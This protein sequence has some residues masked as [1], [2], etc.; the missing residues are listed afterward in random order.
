[1][2]RCYAGKQC[3]LEAG[4]HAVVYR[5]GCVCIVMLL[6]LQRVMGP[7]PW[8]PRHSRAASSSRSAGRRGCW[9]P[10]VARPFR[11]LGMGVDIIVGV[12][13]A[14]CRCCY[15][16]VGFCD[17]ANHR[18]GVQMIEIMTFTYL[19]CYMKWFLRLAWRR[20]VGYRLLVHP[21][22]LVEPPRLL[23]NSNHLFVLS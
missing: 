3:K 7:G 18:T 19:C 17:K 9:Q 6:K 15:R 4:R 5:G 8:T 23:F 10:E 13:C 11:G 12:E 20:G 14:F 21:L 22:I 16:F 2:V 1:M